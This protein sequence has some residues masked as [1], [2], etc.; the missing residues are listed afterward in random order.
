[1]AARIKKDDLVVVVAGAD[2]GMQGRVLKVLLAE[3]RVIVEGVHRIKRHQSPRQYREG[4]IVEREAPI[5]MSNVM[6][7]DPKTGK[8][9]RVR[10]GTD[11]EG[12]KVRLAKSG[13]AIEQ[14]QS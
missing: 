7:V 10:A 5:H 2:K 12:N 8:R 11:K 13:V 3:D 14:E 1:M 9:T 6:L 4:G